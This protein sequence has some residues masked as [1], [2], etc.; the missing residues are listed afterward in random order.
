MLVRGVA[1]VEEALEDKTYGTFPMPLVL[2]LVRYVKLHWRSSTPKWSR[3]RLLER[4]GERC[5][6]CGKHASTVDHVVPRIKGGGTTWENTVAACMKCNGKKG[7]RTLEQSG[8]RL[9]FKP[10]APTWYEINK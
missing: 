7:S 9:G 4:D 1:V 3:R 8:M 2:R 10:Y 5:A 6:Y